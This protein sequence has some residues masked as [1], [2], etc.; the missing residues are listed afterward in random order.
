M[1]VFGCTICTG[2]AEGL[3]LKSNFLIGFTALLMF[4][5][6][7]LGFLGFGAFFGFTSAF[8]LLASIIGATFATCF[9]GGFCCNG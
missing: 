2:L 1:A 5:L 4:S 6:Q 3:V 7:A 9:A 8:A